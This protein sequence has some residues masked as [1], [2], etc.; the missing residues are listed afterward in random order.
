MDVIVIG[1]HGAGSWCTESVNVEIVWR[2]LIA[3]YIGVDGFAEEV[4]NSTASGIANGPSFVVGEIMSC[5]V[6]IEPFGNTVGGF[7]ETSV[8]ASGTDIKIREPFGHVVVI[9]WSNYDKFLTTGESFVGNGSTHGVTIFFGRNV[10]AFGVGEAELVEEI[11]KLG[12]WSGWVGGVAVG[13]VFVAGESESIGN[14]AKFGVVAWGWF[15]EVFITII[16]SAS[17]VEGIED[18]IPGIVWIFYEAVIWVSD[19][20]FVWNTGG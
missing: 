10:P 7:G 6:L 20:D 2:H 15:C 17:F 12:I 13:L 11:I 16:N 9:A 18:G 19:G 5:D 14:G 1:S 4:D 8:V 3:I